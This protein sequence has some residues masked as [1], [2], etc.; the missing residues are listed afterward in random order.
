MTYAAAGSAALSQNGPAPLRSSDRR[1]DAAV[2][3]LVRGTPRVRPV[4][5]LKE[6]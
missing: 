6:V 3:V 4:M 1:V 5:S 2:S